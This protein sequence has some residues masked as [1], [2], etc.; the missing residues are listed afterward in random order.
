MTN[1][2][3][4]G[5]GQAGH[6]HTPDPGVFAGIFD[7]AA[8]QRYVEIL[9]HLIQ[10]V[11][12][13]IVNDAENMHVTPDEVKGMQRLRV[14]LIDRRRRCALDRLAQL[15]TFDPPR[16]PVVLDPF[17]RAV[18]HS[19]QGQPLAPVITAPAV[20][21]QGLSSANVWMA[22]DHAAN[23][24]V[25]YCTDV[26]VLVLYGHAVTVWWDQQGERHETQQG[27]LQHLLIPRGVPHAAINRG[28]LPV[29]AVE[30]RSNPVFDADNQC[31]PALQP[32]VRGADPIA[33][34][35]TGTL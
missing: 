8:L 6:D 16:H 35:T 33:P 32:A 27:P 24:H 29:V 21:T 22:P 19:T 5:N 18:L 30:F 34:A 4:N 3:V 25:H 11:D 28:S 15:A 31:L 26:G 23:A 17:D 14:E 9:A 7:Q 10:D 2:S 13:M 1:C 20:A 12:E